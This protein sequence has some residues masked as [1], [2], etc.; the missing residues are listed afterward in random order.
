MYKKFL[1]KIKRKM[2]IPTLYQSETSKVRSYV[3]KFC[4]G[5]GCDIGFGGDKIQ[6]TNCHGI[7]LARPYAYTG[8]D[9]VDISCDVMHEKIPVED[10]HYDYVYSSHLIEDFTDTKSALEEFIRILKSGGNLVLVFPDQMIYEK[11]CQLTGQPLNTHHIHKDMGYDYMIKQLK[12]IDNISL[13]I[14]FESNCKIDYNV[15][16]VLK[17]TKWG[18]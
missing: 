8:K 10:N 1:K 16:I 15:I 7:D 5:L 4:E 17:I 9:K 12:S 13:E 18:N 11:Y 6:K 3:I 14:L 2:G